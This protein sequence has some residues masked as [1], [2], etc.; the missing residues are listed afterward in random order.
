MEKLGDCC[1]KVVNRPIDVHR[2][3]VAADRIWWKSILQRRAS[4]VEPE[5]AKAVPDVEDDPSIAGIPNLVTHFTRCV[6][7]RN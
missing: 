3:D 5:A 2:V 4:H 1:G 7:N 6:Q